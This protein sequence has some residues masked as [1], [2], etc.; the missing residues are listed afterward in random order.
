[1]ELVANSSGP[2]G[3]GLILGEVGEFDIPANDASSCG[4]FGE[5]TA[6]V[7]ASVTR[8]GL[9]LPCRSVKIDER[10]ITCEH[11]RRSRVAPVREDIPAETVP[12]DVSMMGSELV[13]CRNDRSGQRYIFY[14]DSN[15]HPRQNIEDIY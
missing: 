13:L 12:T 6:T 9:W 15:R 8:S 3:L 4:V 7:S 14:I 11:A 10:S 5:A 2:L 1:V